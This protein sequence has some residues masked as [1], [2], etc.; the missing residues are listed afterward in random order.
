M[1][2]H[3]AEEPSG[4]LNREILK[5]FFAVSGDGP[6]NFVHNRGQEHIPE[7]WYRRPKS[8]QYNLP[9]V[10]TDVL[11]N[12]AMYPGI[13]G[14]G[15]NTGKVNSYVGVDTGDLT[16]GVFNL[17]SLAEGNNAACFF[18]QASQQGLPDASDPLLGAVGSIAGWAA[19]QLG[20][21]SQSLS[22]PQLAKFDNSLFK[23]F[24]GA[25]YKAEEQTK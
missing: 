16:G 8:N 7:N 9:N 19:Q 24:P 23:Q 14:I 4:Y 10:V 13:V 6:G 17:G 18:L 1:S 15:G 25:S 2:N 5:T 12:N 22:C 3:S 21:L 11:T 20:P